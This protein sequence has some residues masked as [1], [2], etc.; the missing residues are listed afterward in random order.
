MT[1]KKIDPEMAQ[2]QADLLQSIRDMKAGRVHRVALT[3][4]AQARIKSGLSQAGFAELL[5]V[6]IKTLQNSEKG[7]TQPSGAAS[8]LIKVAMHSPKVLVKAMKNVATKYGSAHVKRNYHLGSRSRRHLMVLKKGH[9]P[10][11]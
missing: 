2:F 11:Q 9:D 1:S 10:W 3:P 5:G 8:T 4:A 7:R 6:S